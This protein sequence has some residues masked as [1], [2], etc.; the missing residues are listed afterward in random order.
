MIL[1][2]KLVFVMNNRINREI[3][4]KN[5]KELNTRRQSTAFQSLVFK[6]Q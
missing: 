1:T 2:H 5:R 3:T 6:Y 4:I